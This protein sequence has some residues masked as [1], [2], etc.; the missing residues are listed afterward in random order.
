MHPAPQPLFRFGEFTLDT[1]L[2]E[3]RRDGRA[4]DIQPR[5]FDLLVYLITHRDR[6][7]DKG[8][9]QD[10]VW[11]GMVVTETALTRAIMKARK[12]IGDDANRQDFIKTVH[13]HGYRFVAGLLEEARAA[14]GGAAP[15][16]PGAESS[17]PAATGV[18]VDPAGDPHSPASAA[19]PGA[20]PT[21]SA[22]TGNASRGRP[23]RN[24]ILALAALCLV[25]VAAWAW[26]RPVPADAGETRIAVLPLQDETANAELAW[27]R[28]GLMSF[29]SNLLGAEGRLAV[30][31]DG[32]VVSLAESIGWTSGLENDTGETLAARLREVYGAS[33]LLGMQLV[34]EGRGLRMNYSLLG[35]DGEVQ[36]GT[37]VGDTATE[38][39][40]GVVQSLYGRL[41]GRRVRAADSPVVSS[42]PFNN[43]AFARGMDLSLQGR[44][45]EAVSYFHVIIEHEPGLFAPRYEYAACQRVLGKPDLA[46]ELLDTLLEEQRALGPSRQLALVLMTRGIMFNRTGRLDEAEASHREGLE[47]A[48]AVG[49]HDSA[50]RLLHN[51]SIVFED[52]GDL[53][54]AEEFLDLAVLDY[55]AAG[56]E[57]LPGHVYS[58][59]ANLCMDRGELVEA[60]GY[61]DQAIAAFRAA[62]DRRNEAMMLNNTGYLLREMGRLDESEGYHL[63]SLALREE[64]GDRVGVGR[65]YGQLSVLYEAR[66]EFDRAAEAAAGAYQTAL[67]TGDRLYQGTA[68]AQW[69]AAEAS[70]GDRAAAREHYRG[71]R[72]VFAAIQDRMRVLQVD[73]M[74]A[75]LDLDEGALETAELTARD[76]QAAASEAGLNQPEIEALELLGEIALARG[77]LAAAVTT[78]QQA[79]ARVRETSWS[80]K[81]V[82]ITSTLLQTLVAS[83]DLDSAAPLAGALASLEPSS[84]SLQAQAAFAHASDQQPQ[85]VALMEQAKTLAGARWTP[86]NEATLTRYRTLTP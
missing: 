19:Q 32:S 7:I 14:E 43:E 72:E 76:V 17:A 79:L 65:V 70:A 83:G 82:A 64:I 47:V 33:H 18:S 4:V 26:L 22:A 55:R 60:R 84:D 67:E 10:A 12:A 85:A 56:R 71:S 13:G 29:V 45:T 73:V 68:L 86:D 31:A 50:A 37:M 75:R 23:L 21:V 5:A 57:S 80:G 54:R 34:A 52:R 59:R 53:E 11:P 66:G 58:A 69:A 78:Y 8:E 1:G 2:R 16:D 35:P 9:L 15:V 28:L 81:E 38:L 51:L 6:A 61:L 42:D 63:D 27:T 48:R 39:A 36:R 49:D 44:C 40:E 62:G 3:L 46:G 74:L 25:V 24:W 30:V 20:G 41:L 77:D